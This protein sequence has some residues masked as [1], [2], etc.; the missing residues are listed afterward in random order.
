MSYRIFHFQF[1]I[2]V[3]VFN[4]ETIHRELLITLTMEREFRE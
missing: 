4:I 3:N 2:V 1:C